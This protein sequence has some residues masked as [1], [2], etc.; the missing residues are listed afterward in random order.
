[1]VEILEVDNLKIYYFHRDS[2][3]KAVD[4]VSF[5]IPDKS[6]VGIVGES[7]S[8]KSTLASGIIRLVPPP[9]KIV[10]GKIYLDDIELTSLSEDEMREMRGKRI[11]MVFQDP[12]ASLDPLMRVGDQI[13]EAILAHEDMSMDEAVDRANKL[14]NIVGI[15]EERYYSYPHQLSGG[16]RQRVMIAIAMA[17]YPD[18]IIADEPTT[19]LDVVV[20]S[21]IMD[22]FDKLKREFST[23]IMLISHD[24]SLVLQWCDYVGVMYAGELI[25]FATSRGIVEKPRHPYTQ[26]LLRAVPNIEEE[27]EKL[28]SI[29]GSPP[30]LADPPKGCRFHPRCPYVMDICRVESPET[31]LEGTHLVRCWLYE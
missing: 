26:A 3:V 4:G 12:L 20:Q 6:I 16:Q 14:L 31:N 18:L 22:L 10:S 29:P 30:D 2:I 24:I 15:D 19:A 9:G 25:E 5:K 17:L 1:V 13:V 28:Y 27:I 7:G 8:G 21:Q 11:S 23:S